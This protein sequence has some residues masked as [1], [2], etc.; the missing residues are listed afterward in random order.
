M[1]N[2]NIYWEGGA[3][4]QNYQAKTYNPASYSTQLVSGNLFNDTIQGKAD[5]VSL[6]GYNPNEVAEFVKGISPSEFVM[7]Y[8]SYKQS[9]QQPQ[10]PPQQRRPSPNIAEAPSP[11][12]VSTHYNMPRGRQQHPFF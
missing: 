11:S 8:E 12:A 1:A 3:F 4:D 6:K 5:I 2:N 9:S 10:Q 7:L